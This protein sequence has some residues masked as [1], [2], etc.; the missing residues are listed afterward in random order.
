[1]SYSTTLATG[2][3]RHPGYPDFSDVRRFAADLFNAIPPG[4]WAYFADVAKAFQ[5]L[6]QRWALGF[7]PKH[8]AHTIACLVDD[9]AFDEDLWTVP[10][11]RMRDSE[12]HMRAKNFGPIF[13]PDHWAN[14]MFCN[15]PGGRLAKAVGGERYTAAPPQTIRF[16]IVR[17]VRD[18]QW[19]AEN[20]PD[21]TV[22]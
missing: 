18:P 14:T 9:T 15:E 20:L 1:M 6:N 12:G 22:R 2:Y 4:Q 7:N 11:H 16:D 5:F 21:W 10:W 8:N 3:Q 17:H 13:D 19:C